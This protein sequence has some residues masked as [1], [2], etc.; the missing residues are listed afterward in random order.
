MSQH[1]LTSQHAARG[2]RRRSVVAIVAVVVLVVALAAGAGSYLLLRTK[3]SPRQ[4]A[5]SYLQSWQQRGYAALDKV[6]VDLPRSGLAGPLGR[7]AAQLGL[8]RLHLVLGRVTTSGGSALAR[9]T[10]TAQLVSGHTWT[11]PGRLR[12]VKRDHR[13]WVSWSPAAIYPGLGA[14]ERFVLSAVWPARAQVLAADG[15]VL[16]SPQ[17]IARSGSISLLT[18]NVVTATEAQAKALGAPYQA[19]DQIGQG[20]IEQAYQDRLAGRPSLTIRVEGPGDRRDATAAH[21]AASPGAPVKTSLVLADQLAVSK[22]VQSAAT[23]KPVDV[24]ALQPSTGQ[25]LAVVERP[26]GFDRA[27]QGEFPPGSTFKV[28]TASALAKTGMQPSSTVQCPSQVTLGGR[29]FHNDN[30]EQYGTTT[31][32]TAFAVSCN[33]TFA[34]LAS[35]RLGGPALA[36]MATTLGFNAKPALGIP[37]ALGQFTTPSEPVDLAADAFGQGTD[38]VN[39]LSQATVAAAIEDGTWRPPVLVTSPA[40]AQTAQ[41]QTLSPAILGTLRPMMRA[42]VTSGTAAGVGFPPGVYGKTGTA[43][44]GTGANPPSHGWF[45]GYRGDLAF[46]VLVEGGGTGADSAGPIANAFLRGL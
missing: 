34:L 32:Q 30:N 37:A 31:L 6:S 14:G 12:L 35:Q 42:V 45:I 11:Y 38:L 19:G 16:S 24:V 22:A 17:V 10:V 20:G 23:T 9:F 46:A 27:L 36:S 40:P 4:T 2:S 29:T 18:G 44:Y 33:S 21:F 3:G 7:A 25:V 28:V 1:G 5:A 26:G 43:Q 15:T 39:P 8:R 41:P 13:W